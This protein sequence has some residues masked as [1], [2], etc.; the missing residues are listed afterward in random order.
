MV[1]TS[2]IWKEIYKKQYEDLVDLPVFSDEKP[3]ENCKEVLRYIE[4]CKEY[5]KAEDEYYA[6]GTGM[7]IYESK[8]YQHCKERKCQFVN[9][10]FESNKEGL[11]QV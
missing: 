9:K 5:Q 1:E 10:I 4:D 11:H 6:A 7:G 8:D 3:K 2:F